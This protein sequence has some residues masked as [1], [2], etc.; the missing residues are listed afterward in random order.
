MILPSKQNSNQQKQTNVRNAERFGCAA[1]GLMLIGFGLKR[2]PLAAILSSAAGVALIARGATG[3][4][5]MYQKLDINTAKRPQPSPENIIRGA[6]TIKGSPGELYQLW[7][8]P[9]NF[10]CAFDHF[11]QIQ[12]RSDKESHWIVEAPMGKKIEWDSWITGEIP[13]QLIKWKS[14]DDSPLPNHG[15]LTFKSAPGDKGS[16]LVLEMHFDLPVKLGRKLSGIIGMAPKTIAQQALRRFK[17]LVETQ[18]IP[19]ADPQPKARRNGGMYESPL[20]ERG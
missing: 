13:G 4:S 2:R 9:H 19:L 10:V 3:R 17:S 18:E 6:V 14:S 12:V 1:T 5:S 8:D 7:R 16:E 15:K 11:A 20:L